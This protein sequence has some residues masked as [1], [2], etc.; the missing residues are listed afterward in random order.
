MRNKMT[1]TPK[2]P[3][4]IFLLNNAQR[5]LQHW[6]AALQEEAGAH[7]DVVSTPA[8]AGLLFALAQSDGA[9]MGEL[10]TALGL[11]PSAVSGLVQ[12]T[13]AL[14]WVERRSCPQ[15][16]R[17]QRVWLLVAGQAQLPQLKLVTQRINKRLTHGFTPDE[18]EVV[19]RWLTHVQQ[20]DT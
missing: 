19:A 12:R 5:K 6:M 20:L 7:G 2:P 14:A 1:T 3:R 16:A 15:D 18:L 13:E 8:Q 9:T 11:V 4:L 17:T 10:S